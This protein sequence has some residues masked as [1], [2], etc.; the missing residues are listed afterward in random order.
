MVVASLLSGACVVST[1]SDPDYAHE[2]RPPPPPP[3]GSSNDAVGEWTKLGEKLVNGTNDHDD[4]LVGKSE[5][6]FRAL[7]LQIEGSSLK[8]H[9]IV[10]EFTDGSRFSPETRLVFG[11]GVTS[12]VIDLPGSR[13]HIKRVGMRYSNLKGGGAARVEV[14]GR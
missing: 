11:E 1:N 5:G 7:R 9:D 10:V 12:H 4:I 8:M 2:R 6:S 14:W 13:R 3:P